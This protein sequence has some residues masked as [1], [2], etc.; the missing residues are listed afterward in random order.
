MEMSAGIHSAAWI[1]G[2]NLEQDEEDMEL[3][4]TRGET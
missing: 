3:M 4:R 2:R 1:A